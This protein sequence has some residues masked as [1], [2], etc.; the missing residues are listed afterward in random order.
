M[1]TNVPAERAPM[2]RDGV[3]VT[4]ALRLFGPMTCEACGKTHPGGSARGL[5]LEER[6]GSDTVWTIWGFGDGWT[7]TD[8][9]AG[10]M[11]VCPADQSNALVRILRFVSED[12]AAIPGALELPA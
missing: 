2:R 7:T 9:L 1:A 8:E 11:A 10:S 4:E 3:L 12:T 5:L 6:D